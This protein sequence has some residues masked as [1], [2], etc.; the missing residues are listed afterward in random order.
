MMTALLFCLKAG[1]I[2]TLFYKILTLNGLVKGV[3]SS[4]KD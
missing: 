1:V 2:V 3:E 4:A